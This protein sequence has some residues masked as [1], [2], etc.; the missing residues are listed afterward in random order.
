MPTC[1]LCDWLRRVGTR[2]RLN[3][4]WP[5]PAHISIS[6]PQCAN[7]N[8]ATRGS[9]S[10]GRLDIKL[11]HQSRVFDHKSKTASLPSNLCD[12]NLYT[13]KDCLYIETAPSDSNG[14]KL[15][16]QQQRR[17]FSMNYTAS[18]TLPILLGYRLE[19]FVKLVYSFVHLNNLLSGRHL[20]LL[21]NENLLV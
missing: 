13:W 11:F 4:W 1:A 15:Y 20:R 2:Q 6:I 9:N 14:E 21:I 12:G 8:N 10:S 7:K 5:N 18:N 19:T 16:F 3:Q 17:T